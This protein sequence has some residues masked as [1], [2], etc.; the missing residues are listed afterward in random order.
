MDCTGY[1]LLSIAYTKISC[2]V[3]LIGVWQ[4]SCR[5]I[6]CGDSAVP[7][8]PGSIIAYIDEKICWIIA[9]WKYLLLFRKMRSLVPDSH[10]INP[11][12]PDIKTKADRLNISAIFP[13]KSID[14]SG[15]H[16]RIYVKTSIHHTTAGF[17]AKVL[18]LCRAVFL[19]AT[20][21]VMQLHC[22]VPIAHTVS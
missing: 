3:T 18:F 13:E 14:F 15:Y 6:A 17:L 19:P 1:F 2:K 9:H 5:N 10:T 8:F 7:I 16:L 22:V 4:D 21:N 20:D 12:L 11:L